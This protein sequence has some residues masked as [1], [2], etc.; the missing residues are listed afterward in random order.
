MIYTNDTVWTDAK[1]EYYLRRLENIPTSFL[2]KKV[3]G[4]SGLIKY[5][6]DT[7]QVSQGYYNEFPLKKKASK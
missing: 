3:K 2:L 5:I 6:K 4:Y 7:R 1:S